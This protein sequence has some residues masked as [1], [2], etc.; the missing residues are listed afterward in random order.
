MILT[1]CKIILAEYNNT[2]T[3]YGYNLRVKLKNYQNCKYGSSEC[4]TSKMYT[5]IF[6]NP[7]QNNNIPKLILVFSRFFGPDNLLYVKINVLDRNSF[8]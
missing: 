4:Q 8:Q 2:Q 6:D 7:N 5:H 3:V 1:E